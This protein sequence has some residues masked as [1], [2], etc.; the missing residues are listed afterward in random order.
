MIDTYRTIKSK[1]ISVTIDGHGSDELFIGYGHIKKA[2]ANSNNLNQIS[3][4]N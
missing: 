2:I 4:L 3:E 1:G